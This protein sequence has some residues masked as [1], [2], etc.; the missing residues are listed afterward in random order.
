MCR[1][2]SHFAYVESRH[3]S[4]SRLLA[5]KSLSSTGML[6]CVCDGLSTCGVE[7][8]VE[9]ATRLA[10]H[11]RRVLG[12]HVRPQQALAFSTSPISF[13]FPFPLTSL[14]LRASTSKCACG[15]DTASSSHHWQGDCLQPM[16]CLKESGNWCTFLGA[17]WRD[18]RDTVVRA[19][20]KHDSGW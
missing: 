6:V 15:P 13:K 19:Q 12:Y 5:T 1:S 8:K 14:R 9:F 18:I 10:K 20:R 4:I 17:L 3:L 11:L 2:A 7:H 16:H